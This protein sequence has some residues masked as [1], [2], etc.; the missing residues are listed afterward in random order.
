LYIVSLFDG[1]VIAQIP[2]ENLNNA[3][4]PIINMSYDDLTAPPTEPLVL[5]MGDPVLLSDNETINVSAWIGDDAIYEWQDGNTDHDRTISEAGVYTVT[6]NKDAFT[7]QGALEVNSTVSAND[8]LHLNIDFS[9]AP[10]P[11]SDNILYSIESKRPLTGQLVLLDAYGRVLQTNNTVENTGSF[12]VKQMP[13]GT[14]SLQYREGDQ[15]LSR[16]V[17]V[18]N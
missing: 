17:L 4:V 6:V 13:T 12:S 14:Y 2:I 10:N 1:T 3:V 16:N 18:V 15:V 11:T 5:D 8:D 9:V 7:I